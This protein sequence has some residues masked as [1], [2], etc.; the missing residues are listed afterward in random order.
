MDE[1]SIVTT[2]KMIV[3]V[4]TVANYTEQISSDLIRLI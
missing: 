2:A 4:I 3:H 1:I